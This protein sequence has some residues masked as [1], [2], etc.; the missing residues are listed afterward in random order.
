M[1]IVDGLTS[2]KMIRSFEK[3]HPS[4]LMSTG[5]SLKGR[6]P[7]F[8]VSASL[9]ERERQMYTD[10]GFDAWI[11]KP[12][13]FARLAN[14][15][16]GIADK[17][18]REAALY[19]PGKWENGGWFHSTQLDIWKADTK[20]VDGRMPVQEELASTE[21]KAA[22]QTEDPFAAGGA[23]G[24]QGEE[25]LRLEHGEHEK[26]KDDVT[27]G[28]EGENGRAHEKSGSDPAP[29]QGSQGSVT[30]TAGG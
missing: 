14:L 2:T 12:I 16:K 11:L 25:Q 22:A 8:A 29:G 10:A 19:T 30:P 6:V 17:E 18:K 28:K 13:N 9:L 24:R 23:E 15:M 1:P 21:M 3:A 20:P 27:A 26:R 4:H 7:I 5:A